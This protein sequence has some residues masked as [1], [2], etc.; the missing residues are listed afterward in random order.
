[1][2]PIGNLSVEVDIVLGRS[3][4]PIHQLLRMGRG[5][6]IELEASEHDE[7]E[8][9]ANDMPIARGV[10]VVEGSRIIVEI[11][12]MMRKPVGDATPGRG[13]GAGG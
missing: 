2:G 1:M 3:R 7:V 13:F 9:V 12:D 8:I 11:K 10:L 4:M 6:V 5:A